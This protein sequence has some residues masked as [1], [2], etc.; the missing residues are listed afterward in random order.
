MITY[1]LNPFVYLLLLLLVIWRKRN[2][3]SRKT[4][5]YRIGLLAVLFYLFS[6][7]FLITP[8][9]ER[10]EDT[11]PPIRL[12]ELDTAVTYHVLV[13]GAGHGY[14]SRL[15]ANARLGHTMLSRLVEGIRIYRQLSHARL[16][17]SANSPYGLASQ[18][19][20]VRETAIL[21]GVDSS[22][23]YMQEEPYNTAT[24][25]GS[26]VTK[27]GT[28]TPL[29]LVTSARHMP[30]AVDWFQQQGVKQIIPAPTDFV[31]KKDQP[32]HWRRLLPDLSLFGLWQS[33]LKE[34]SWELW[35]MGYGL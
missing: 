32:F 15:P 34:F 27:W 6:T 1:I 14:D 12:T 25:A 20:V 35:V 21:L 23:I 30:R 17:T 24:E 4:L 16:I 31:I 11:H 13:L 28:D 8:L 2:K 18:A 7:P 33:T 26:Y 10:L 29:I 9:V 3:L 19:S 5:R 22:R